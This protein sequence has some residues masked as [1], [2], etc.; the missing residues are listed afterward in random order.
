MG[1]FFRYIAYIDCYEKGLRV[2]NA[3]YL[4]WKMTDDR[5][6]LEIEIKEEKAAD[7]Q[8]KVMEEKTGRE[9]FS[10]ELYKGIG[11]LKK[12]LTSLEKDNSLFLLLPKMELDL[13][14]VS[15]LRID[16]GQERILR[17]PLE[18]PLPPKMNHQEIPSQKENK[19]MGVR[20]E[21][22]TGTLKVNEPIEKGVDLLQTGSGER[23]V[24]IELDQEKRGSSKSKLEKEAEVEKTMG[25]K[26]QSRELKSSQEKEQKREPDIHLPLEEDKWQQLCRSYPLVHPFPGGRAFLSI[27]PEDFILLQEGYQRL[28]HNSFL[29]H[30]YYSYRH[31]ILGKL[32]DGEDK[33]YYIGVPGVFYEKE[34]QAAGLFGFAGFEGTEY[35]VRNGSHGYYMIEVKI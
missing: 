7:G 9:L 11:S 3:G 21:G 13:Y 4:R 20:Q 22:R 1:S 31:M 18:L 19:E 27:K 8:Y 15:A 30:G 14:E 2:N 23:Q 29:L 24:Q 28:V 6:Q 26:H 10:I 34:K 12:S 35:P 5:H 17:I 33:P 25:E 32:E 16:L